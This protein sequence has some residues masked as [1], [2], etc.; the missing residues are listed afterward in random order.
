MVACELDNMASRG[1]GLWIICVHCLI[2]PE[3]LLSPRQHRFVGSLLAAC[4]DTLRN[5]VMGEEALLLPFAGIFF[6][7]R[8]Y[9]TQYTWTS[10]TLNSSK[11]QPLKL[12]TGTAQAGTQQELPNYWGYDL[13]HVAT[14]MMHSEQRTRNIPTWAN[15]RVRLW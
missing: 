1:K 15:S 8:S 2:L 9:W 3:I 6:W 10:E 13:L 7:C 14:A 5:T 11:T 12:S 4:L